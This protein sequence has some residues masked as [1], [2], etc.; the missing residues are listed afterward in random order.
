MT[1]YLGKEL[2]HK[3]QSSSFLMINTRADCKLAAQ[4]VAYV[5]YV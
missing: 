1:T 2:S 3:D 5:L 4:C